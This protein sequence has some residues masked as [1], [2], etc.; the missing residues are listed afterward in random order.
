ML[1]YSTHFLLSQKPNLPS[2]WDSSDC[3]SSSSA[4]TTRPSI[5]W[6]GGGPEFSPPCWP[7]AIRRRRRRPDTLVDALMGGLFSNRWV[8]LRL[9][10]LKRS[11]ALTRARY[12]GHVVLKETGE[13]DR[14]TEELLLVT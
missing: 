9:L 6:E 10:S 13:T 1:H 11:A 12:I 4:S 2:I 5:Q 7:F 14:R 3:E 8:W